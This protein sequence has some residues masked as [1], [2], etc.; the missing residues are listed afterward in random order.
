M[1]FPVPQFTDVEDK[2]I[3]PLTI[4]QFGIIFGV[5]AIVFVSYSITK[6]FLVTAFFF[7]LFGLPGLGLALVPFNGRPMY[8]FI[9]QFFKFFTSPKQMVFHKEA[10][11]VNFEV[12]FKNQEIPVKEEEPEEPENIDPKARM[13]E[14]E[15]ML[16]KTAL[17]EKNIA[18]RIR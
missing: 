16:N 11:N 14:V 13:H 1:Q 9:G 17:E 10:R 6:S 18:D 4:K 7:V 2:I 3:G 8:A 5:G 12:N 15:A